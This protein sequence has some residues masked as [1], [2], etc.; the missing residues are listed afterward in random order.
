MPALQRAMHHAARFL[1]AIAALV[2]VVFLLAI[3]ASM[4]NASDTY[5]QGGLGSVE[6]Y[7]SNNQDYRNTSRGFSG[8]YVSLL[9]ITVGNGEGTLEDGREFDGVEIIEVFPGGS[10][11]AA[12]L[13]GQRR[14]V[15]TLMILAT[16]AASVVFPPA[17]M[18]VA[19]LGSSHIGESHEFVIAVDAIRTHDV[20]DFEAALEQAKPGETVYLT[21]VRNGQREQLNV[22]LSGNR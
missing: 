9:G 11:A 3:G 6:D 20:N 4:S 21:V 1:Q 13:K 19:L 15:Q 8:D 2:A 22:P 18:G 5:S 14:Q 17:V 16:V 12:G 7:M 10:A